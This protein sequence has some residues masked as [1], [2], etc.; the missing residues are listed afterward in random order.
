MPGLFNTLLYAG[1]DGDVEK[2]LSDWSLRGVNLRFHSL[3]MDTCSFQVAGSSADDDDLFL[4]GK[5]CH[6]YVGR[7][8]DDLSPTGFS[9]G[10][11]I[12]LGLVLGPTAAATGRQE[13]MSFEL[14]G[15]W[16]YLE[17]RT[18]E[19]LYKVFDHY[20]TP[21]DSTTPIVTRDAHSGHLFLNRERNQDWLNTA[22][23]MQDAVEWAISKGA[24]IQ[25]LPDATVDLNP[26][27]PAPVGRSV[28]ISQGI[29]GYVD[30]PVD[31]VVDVTCAEV[32][33]KQARWV[34]DL[35]GWFDYSTTPF[36]TFKAF[37]R[38]DMA[39]KPIGL[40][41]GDDGGPV[42]AQLRPRYD[43]LRP[44]VTVHFEVYSS[45]DGVQNFQLVAQSWPD[46]PPDEGLESFGGL[47]A[48][49]RIAGPQT[50]RSSILVATAAVPSTASPN[51]A[52]VRAFVQLFQPWITD[53]DTVSGYTVLEVSR[54]SA[55]GFY[56]VPGSGQLTDWVQVGGLPAVEAKDTVRVRVKITYRNGHVEDRVVPIDIQAT[57]LNTGGG[58][59]KYT[60]ITGTLSSDIIPPRLARDLYDSISVLAYSGS[61]TLSGDEC[62]T[63]T[64]WLGDRI[65]V[66]GSPK[67]SGVDSVVQ[68]VDLDLDAGRTV[69]RFGPAKTLEAGDYVELLK[70][71]RARLVI[72]DPGS[73]DAGG[74]SQPTETSLGNATPYVNSTSGAGFKQVVVASDQADASGAKRLRLDSEDTSLTIDRGGD[75]LVKCGYTD[76]EGQSIRLRWV[77][78]CVTNPDGSTTVKRAKFFCSDPIA[79]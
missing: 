36:L 42:D 72:G 6:V 14:G 5:L 32:I 44:F 61:L 41:D 16:W 66:S 52:A 7:E 23:Q 54:D 2:K 79:L 19:M 45:T 25:L 39:V 71:T 43:L 12:F 15:P 57:N 40:M 46:P 51:A 64:A 20:E 56:M 8:E 62:D 74:S 26:G 38:S 35:V 65:S 53:P 37:R 77:N 73:R 28:P 18:F 76:A 27:D 11:R 50:Q 69:I 78:V 70:V 1:P 34:P 58:T 10:R 9:G 47:V 29:K 55:L 59:R 63:T 60:K 22:Q 33:R 13:S 3:D 49:I 75:E 17:N 30:V 4:S 67:Y 21:G 48:T 24:P 31:E 68:E